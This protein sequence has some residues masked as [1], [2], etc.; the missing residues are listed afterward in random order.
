MQLVSV[1][2]LRDPSL[3]L[4]SLIQSIPARFENGEGVWM[5]I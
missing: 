4:T 1:E 5:P 3:H 2:F